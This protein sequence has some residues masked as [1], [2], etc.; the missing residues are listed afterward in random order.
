MRLSKVSLTFG[1]AAVLLA[2]APEMSGQVTA[3]ISLDKESYTVGEP[4][5][6]VLEIKNASKEAI[7][8]YPRLPGQNIGNFSFSMQRTTGKTRDHPVEP[9]G[10]WGRTPP[11]PTN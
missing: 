6:F 4:L 9:T 7:Q 8:L 2:I 11:T 5:F 10:F 3:R 1:L